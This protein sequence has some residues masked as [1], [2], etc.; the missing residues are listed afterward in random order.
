MS[1]PHSLPYLTYLMS[2][3]TGRGRLYDRTRAAFLVNAATLTE[4]AIGGQVGD[5]HGSPRVLSAEPTGD[6]VLDDLLTRVTAHRR[7][8]KSWLRHHYRQTLALVETELESAGVI[9]V[10]RQRFG[11]RQVAVLDPAVVV[12]LQSRVR[13]VMST[14]HPGRHGDTGSGESGGARDA[15]LGLLAVAGAVR[16]VRPAR[17]DEPGKG[18]VRELAA[19]LDAVASP[20]GRVIPSL[21][22]TMV[23]AQGGMGGS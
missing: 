18:H 15:A 6:A 10:T 12:A 8:W 5:D 22:M 9:T 20:L 2:Y 7:S 11:R 19:R 16:P 17:G 13:D 23:A 1:S 14:G 21:R 3:D 4:L